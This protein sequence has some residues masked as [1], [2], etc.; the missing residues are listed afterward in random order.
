MHISDCQVTI[1]KYCSLLSEDLSFTF[2]NSVDPDKMQYNAAF[3]L[4]FSV[5]KS[6][7]LG[8]SRIQRIKG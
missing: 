8:V 4:L 3:H 7:N 6:T 5:C 2:T 1:F